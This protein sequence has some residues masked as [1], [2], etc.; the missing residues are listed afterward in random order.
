MSLRVAVIGCGA[1]ARRLH[2]PAMRDAGADAVAF[3]SGSRASASAAAADWGG[4]IVFDHWRTAI[5]AAGV[6][7]VD[8][9]TPNH[10][11]AEI[12]I[13]AARAGKHVLVEKPIAPT[14]AEADAMIDAAADAG[15]VLMVAQSARYA[16]PVRAI[17]AAVRGGAIGTVRSAR[18]VLRNEG[19]EAWSPGSTWFTDPARGGGGALLD[20]GVHVADLLRALFE[21]DALEVT[22]MCRPEAPAEVDAHAVIRFEDDALA[23]M[24]VGW[25]SRGGTDV[26]VEVAGEVGVIRFDGVRAPFVRA[27][28]RE[29]DVPPGAPDDAIAAFARAVAGREAP[30]VS[31]E[32]GRAALAIVAAAYSSARAGT[33]TKV[34]RR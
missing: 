8:I 2:L 32:D 11:H 13:A 14:L 27:A 7:A 4:G 15:V 5:E 18:A 12:A 21:R 23:T 19:P 28:D 30:A 22:A 1:A 25:D 24:Q 10:M 9:C 26:V 16:P 6:D 33:T 3:A 34:D 29:S 20:L 31:G 17:L